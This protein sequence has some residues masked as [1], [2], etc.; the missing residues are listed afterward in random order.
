MEWGRGQIRLDHDT[1]EHGQRR[2]QAYVCIAHA[3][4][5]VET[6]T[7]RSRMARKKIFLLLL[8]LTDCL[9]VLIYRS[10]KRHKGEH[11]GNSSAP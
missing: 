4:A 2:D 7:A 5:H 8:L 9:F 1:C 10:T 3:H 6:C 11:H